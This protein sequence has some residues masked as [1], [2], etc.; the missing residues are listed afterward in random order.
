MPQYDL[1]ETIIRATPV[2]L[3]IA[4]IIAILLVIAAAVCLWRGI[5]NQ[6]KSDKL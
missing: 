3:N 5:V 1:A 4:I 2:I 6:K